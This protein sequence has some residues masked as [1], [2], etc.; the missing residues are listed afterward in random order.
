MR[1]S[2]HVRRTALGTMVAAAAALAPAWGLYADE[3]LS[4]AQAHSDAGGRLAAPGPLA[5]G[6]G[7][8]TLRLRAIVVRAWDDSIAT[9]KRLMPQAPDVGMVSLR[10]VKRLAPNNCYGLYAGEGPA[11]CSG[12]E[13][14]FV[15]VG[16]ADRLMAR[17]GP[18]AESGIAF[19]IGHEIG[20][21]IQ[22]IRGRFQMLNYMMARMPEARA[23]L[24][25]RFELEADCF[26]GVWIH[27]SSAWAHS[28]RFRTQLIAVLGSI[29][30]ESVLAHVPKADAPR[31]ALHGT[32]AQRRRWF[33]RGADS[34][35]PD[36]C[37]TF[38]ARDL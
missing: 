19:L 8:S 16:A 22:N 14:V 7:H 12:N 35:D 24:A 25:R 2:T 28:A 34:G 31:L 18:Q 26:A 36:A 37:N 5:D 32:S 30:D 13:T 38:I 21:H 29:G 10:L 17:F 20:H 1:Q 27:A 23:D 9:W 11:Y 15:G 4:P 6:E 3:R 33:L